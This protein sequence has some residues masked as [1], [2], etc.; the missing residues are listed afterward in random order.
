MRPLFHI[1]HAELPIFFSVFDAF[2]EAFLLRCAAHVQVELQD[3]GALARQ[4]LLEVADA[5]VTR[6]PEFRISVLHGVDAGYMLA[7]QVF[8]M[9]FYHQHFLVVASVVHAD[10]AFRRCGLGMAPQEI[11]VQFLRAR[12]LEAGDVAPLGVHALQHALDAAVLAARVHGLEDQEQ[13]MA[14]LR[15]QLLLEFAYLFRILLHG[16]F[17]FILV[18]ILLRSGIVFL[19]AE[20]PAIR[21]AMISEVEEV[22]HLGGNGG[23]KFGRATPNANADQRIME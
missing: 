17:Q 4:V 1:A 2:Q 14:I 12:R 3:G 15:V 20:V 10:H 21:N 6:V 8:R 5:G 16:L 9:H 22:F 23:A 19:Q 7:Q 11:V 13:R 18:D